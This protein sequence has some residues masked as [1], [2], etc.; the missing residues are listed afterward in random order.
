MS[1]QLS[2]SHYVE[3]LPIKNID[4]INYYINQICI[5]NISIRTLRIVIK[6]KEYERLDIKTKNKLIN[7]QKNSVADFV[8]NPILIRNSYNYDNISENMLQNLILED[9]TSLT[10]IFQLNL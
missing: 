9:I 10:E 1:H 8:K 4:E 6:S 3:L 7:R 5:N 2:R